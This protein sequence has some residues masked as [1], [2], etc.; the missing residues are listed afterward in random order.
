MVN[1]I[2]SSRTLTPPQAIP[3]KYL[4]FELSAEHYAISVMQIRKIIE[5]VPPTPVPLMPGFVRG[6]LQ[7]LNALVPILDLAVYFGHPPIVVG[8]QTC[9]VILEIR[10]AQ[11]YLDVGII[12]DAVNNVVEVAADQIMAS[13]HFGD[14]IRSEF[15][16]G[17]FKLNEQGILLLDINQL[18]SREDLKKIRT[19]HQQS[20]PLSLS[21]SGSVL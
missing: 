3:V 9:V 20:A 11:H 8:K 18:F 5:F 4:S 6:V 10:D 12:V 17:L 19:A 15:I 1:L 7:V 16:L 21:Q 13:P 14:D 2:K